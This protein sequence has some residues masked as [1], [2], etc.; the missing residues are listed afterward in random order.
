MLHQR[1]PLVVVRP[2]PLPVNLPVITPH[3]L[4]RP[5]DAGWVDEINAALHA[6]IAAKLRRQ[7]QLLGIAVLNVRHWRSTASADL[8]V[9]TRAALRQWKLILL[10]WTPEEI[11]DFLPARTEFAARLRRHSPFVGVLTPTEQRTALAGVGEPP[12]AVAVA[13]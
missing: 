4:T 6:V 1:E 3:P 5:A 2:C 13:A 8:D 12:R 9:E 7:P 10:T 11:A